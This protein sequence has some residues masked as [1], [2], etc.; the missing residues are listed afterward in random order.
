MKTTIDAR[1]LA[2]PKPVILTKKG[3]EGIKEGSIKT[4]VDN[5]IAKDNLSKLAKSMNLEYKVEQDLD[6]NYEVTTIKGK[7]E[8][9]N[10]T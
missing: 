9:V 5:E 10:Y 3:I 4:I 2:C 1:G 6:G 7:E 8:H